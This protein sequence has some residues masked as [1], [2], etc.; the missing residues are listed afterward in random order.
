MY[1]RNQYTAAFKKQAI[2]LAENRGNSSAARHLGVTESTIRGWMKFRERIFQAAP[3]RKAFRGPKTGRFPEIEV[4]LAE[5]VRQRRGQF[6]PVNAELVQ[7]KARELAR[8][9]GVPR[10]TF[11]ASRSWVQ[12]FMRRAGF[13]L[14]RRTSICQK[15]PAEYEEKLVEFQRYV[16]KMRR[17]KNYPLGQIGNADET[18]IFLDIPAGYVIDQLGTKEVR[19][20]TTGNEKT[21]VTVMLACTADGRKLPP[22]L[23]FK[24]KT[25]PK[26]ETFPHR[27]HVRC[28]DKGWMDSTMMTEW[29]RVVWGRRPGAL[30]NT[31]VMIVLDAFRGHLTDE[32]KEALAKANTDLVVI[33]GGMTSQLQP[34]DVCINKPFKD[35]VRR[36]YEQWLEAS[37]RQ[38]TPSGRMKR[39]SVSEVAR[40]IHNA[41]E[42]LPSAIVSRA[43]LK[44]CLSNS[45]DGTDDDAVF[46]DSDKDSSSDDD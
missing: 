1:K 13:S 15:L 35:L 34:L 12:K 8:E 18:P 4:D 36:E 16:I 5:F 43:F 24:R 17:E 6:L 41:W 29:I 31:P 2:L 37:N 42:A 26:N 21:R 40:W 20:R 10:D 33:P 14:R 38:L 7:I 39:A 46:V 22:F 19:V 25:L 3:T 23:I 44:C 27:M 9:A 28:N 11:K 30:L 32:V 45:L